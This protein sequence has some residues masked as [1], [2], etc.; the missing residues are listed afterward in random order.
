MNCKQCNTIIPT[1]IT[2][3]GKRHNLQR[4][5]YCT[6]CSPFGVH[7]TGDPHKISRRGTTKKC[8]GC[9]N[10]IGQRRNYCT[11]CFTTRY[12]HKRKKL[13][14]ELLGGSCMMC[15]Y[16]RCI[17][18]LQFHHRDPKHKEFTISYG[19][20][21]KLERFIAEVKKCDLLCATCHIERHWPQEYEVTDLC[22][23]SVGGF[24]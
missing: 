2:I 5:K 13:G 22:G 24:L 7:N 9:S 23:S 16:N 17:A 8:A 18:A 10:K 19:S 14:V 1:N 6:N 15:G 11:T 3:D 12:R 21:L 20:R 4:R